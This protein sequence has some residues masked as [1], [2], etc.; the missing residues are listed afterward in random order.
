MERALGLGR[1]KKKK[2]KSK[3]KKETYC[4][5]FYSNRNNKTSLLINDTLKALL[6]S[7]CAAQ[8]GKIP[9]GYL[10]E[11]FFFFF[12]GNTI[13]QMTLHLLRY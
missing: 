2:K 13:S 12:F 1:V 5:Y 8:K 11:W 3:Q 6:S 10:T 7:F 9:H 4:H